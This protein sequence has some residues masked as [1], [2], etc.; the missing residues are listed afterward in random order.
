MNQQT[1]AQI[2]HLNPPLTIPAVS[3]IEEG[4]AILERV[5]IAISNATYTKVP[6]ERIRPMPHQP[7]KYFNPERLLRLSESIKSVGQITPGFLRIARMDSQGYD[8]ELVDGERRWRAILMAGIPEF[9]AMLV[10]VDDVAAQYIVSIIANFNREGHTVLEIADAIRV[11]R[12]Q[13]KLDM[14]EIGDMIGYSEVYATNLYGLRRLVPDVRAMLE[15]DAPRNRRLPTTAAIEIS[16]LPGRYQLELAQRVAQREVN[17]RALR[18]EIEQ[19][20]EKHDLPIQRRQAD[21][22]HR[23]QRLE[24][25]VSVVRRAAV[26]L[27]NRLEETPMSIMLDWTLGV[28]MACRG[29]LEVARGNL[30]SAVKVLDTVVSKK[31]GRR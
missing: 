13:L 1:G 26:D 15:P 5:R 19:L 17:L 24:E 21:P 8:H 2:V 25:K 29:E 3:S 16:R 23:R 4:R 18:G 27:K 6:V 9:R 11:S 30:G 22:H 28:V 7:R 10:D 20:S 12:E 14:K 31:S